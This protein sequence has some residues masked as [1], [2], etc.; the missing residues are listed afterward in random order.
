[1]DKPRLTTPYGF[2]LLE[3]LV[4][5][6]V[7]FFVAI[8]S[9]GLLFSLNNL[10]QMYLTQKL[11]F[12]TSTTIVELV[13][14]EIRRADTL[15]SGSV[16]EVA[17]GKL[18]LDQSGTLVEFAISGNDLVVSN[19]AIS[20]SSLTP[21]QVTVDHF[22]VYHYSNPQ[23]ELVRVRLHLTASTTNYITGTEIDIATNIRGSYAP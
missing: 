21:D 3:V 10:Y 1:M 20:K 14:T 16:L 7:L 19:G 15:N 13:T 17:P 9:V 11:L 5:I 4:Y 22:F 6:A 2:T 12:D 23:T 18:V 8:G